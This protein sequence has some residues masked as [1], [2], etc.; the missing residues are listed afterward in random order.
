MGILKRMW[1]T[2]G[3]LALL[4][5]LTLVA[6]ALLTGAP[7][8][9]NRLTDEALRARI[10]GLPFQVKDLTYR[11]EGGTLRP[12]NAEARLEQQRRA[13]DAGLAK[14]LKQSWYSVTTPVES[15]YG[16]DTGFGKPPNFGLRAG[17]GLREAAR[18]VLGRWPDN[19]LDLPRV[20]M[21]L[22]EVSARILNQHVGSDFAIFSDRTRAPV[23]VRVVGI[24]T[25]VDEK[26]PIWD[27]APLA[28]RAY[29]PQS[30]E[31]T[32]QALYLTDIPGVTKANL[33]GVAVAY[34]WRYRLDLSSLDMMVL[35]G[36]LPAILD[37]R[38]QGIQGSSL[39]TGL[40]TALTRFADNARNA[41][42]MFA[43]VQAGT[44]ATLAGLV[45]LSARM[46]A[47]RRRQ[48]F[49]LLRARGA[50]LRT[51][52][53]R[54]LLETSPA[55]VL[56]AS[57][58]GYLGSLAPG[59]A[60]GTGS[61]L[62]AFA[63]VATLALPILAMAASR[64]FVEERS[65]RPRASLRRR[66]AEIGVVALA[67][68]GVWLL[69]RR[70]LEFDL[71]LVAVPVLLAT[72]A[73]IVTLRLI[74]APLALA[75]RI[76]ARA[77]GTVAFLGLI[78]AGRS[79]P[80]AVGPVAVLIV[81]VCTTVFSIGVA[82][83]IGEARELAAD[84]DLP[85]DALVQGNRFAV[86][87]G[88]ELR[89]VPGVSA[90]TPL[91]EL[92]ARTILSSRE[93]GAR[94]LGQTYVL[95]VDG[96][97]F[98]LVA[99]KA[100]RRV[101]VPPVIRDAARQQSVPALASPLVARDLAANGGNGVVDLQGRDYD[102][103]VAEVA[104]D[105]PAIPR[106]AQRFLVLPWQALLIRPDK[107]IIPTSFLVAGDADRSALLEV[108]D[109]GQLRWI[110]SVT[111]PRIGYQPMSKIK[112]WQDRRSELELSGVNGVLSFA[113][114]VG[115]LGGVILALLAVGFT[116]LAEAR[117]RGKALSRLRTMG[118]AQRQGRGLLLFELAP[119][120]TAAVAAGAAVGLFLPAL[121]G[122]ALNLTS[123]TDGFD[124]G[125]RLDP[126]VVGGALGLVLAGLATALLVE[127][128]FNRRTRLG[129]VL[130]VGTE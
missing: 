113:F 43:I 40:D 26:N 14:R 41:Q 120:V 77:R 36:L 12:A 47:I 85:A 31:E 54:A 67:A 108:A 1:A 94:N 101:E 28:V 109:S 11:A 99:E 122:P 75:G 44:L 24:F 125:V 116:V 84:H 86:D 111:E 6:G 37:A 48:E 98:A 7:R 100:G 119:V 4:A 15:T 71:Y 73:A 19:T 129:E 16:V 103:R 62:A 69:R 107:L 22:S 45:L 66:T 128:G 123:F 82:G 114:G 8:I 72:A 121:V 18:L 74:P 55:V 81:A 115:A 93:I 30:D 117:T 70:G 52:A 42:A 68:L 2:A 124:A 59:R 112:T 60:G 58:G 27:T 25:P 127:A 21:A 65:D 33:G 79:A 13:I 51:I 97:T 29:A 118:L 130:R 104:A 106:G 38:R 17:G 91:A 64:R 46:A 83:T 87:T 88:D 53:F 102:F 32:Y 9:A 90:V 20:E 35:P 50:A 5:V 92:S 76:A 34:E 78:R 80:A 110:S 63:F 39:E 105:F 56:A 96:P 49:A 23:K 10:G 89:R 57:I 3:Q 61:L 95:V 126:V